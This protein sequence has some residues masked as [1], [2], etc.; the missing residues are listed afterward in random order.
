[1]KQC[2]CLIVLSLV[3]T[4]CADKIQ[5][6][7]DEPQTLL[8]DPHFAEYQETQ[9]KLE[10]QYLRKEITYAEYLERKGRIEDKYTKEVQD[11]Q[12]VIE[13]NENFSGES[14]EEVEM[15]PEQ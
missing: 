14:T 15:T 2:I 8:Q 3:L 1:M 12:D 7:I 9:D 10:G 5:G 4:G 13:N 11:R 6:Y